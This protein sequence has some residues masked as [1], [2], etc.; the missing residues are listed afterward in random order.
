VVTVSNG[1]VSRFQTRVDE[2]PLPLSRKELW[3]FLSHRENFEL[4]EEAST[5]CL[6]WKV[7]GGDGFEKNVTYQLPMSIVPFEQ[8]VKLE[9]DLV[10]EPAVICKMEDQARSKAPIRRRKRR[11]ELQKLI[12]KRSSAP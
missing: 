4:R 11:N 6:K 12:G 9:P 7:E 10:D 5:F 1:K 2:C 3:E 8:Q